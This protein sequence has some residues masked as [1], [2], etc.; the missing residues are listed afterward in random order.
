MGKKIIINESKLRAIVRNILIEQVVDLETAIKEMGFVK[1]TPGNYKHNKDSKLTI[2]IVG[3]NVIV[4]K[5]NKELGKV[6]KNDIE[7]LE[8]IVKSSF[9]LVSEQV[10]KG[11]GNDP[12][13]YKKEGNVYY[14][15]KKGSS[16]WVKTSGEASKAIASKIFKQTTT[17]VQ[18]KSSTPLLTPRF[19]FD[20]P[21]Q[22]SD[23]LG[24]GG[25]FERNLYGGRNKE[26]YFKMMEFV[27]KFPPAKKSSLPLHIRALMDYLA[28]RETPFTAS[29][30]TRDEQQFIKK[31]AISNAKKGLTYPLWK[32]I[33]AGNLPTSMTVTG[34]QKEKEKLTNKGGEGSLIKPELA[35]QFMYTLGEITPPNIKVSPNK[36]NVTVFDRY[37]FNTKG[38][39][40]ED[41]LN[42]FV[43]QVGSWWKGDSTFYS[44][45]RNAVAFKEA[46]GYKG[47]PVNITV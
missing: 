36:E 21:V 38:K 13:E 20:R 2:S 7:D 44:V 47:F 4:K 30:L 45:V 1:T 32:D 12:Y 9:P 15:R 6:T 46:N 27:K 17:K 43:K 34:S 29:D 37:D 14:A 24:K 3:D 26:D 25:E 19:K 35:G 5:G 23:Y 33:G 18:S 39:T 22:Q 31:V 8:G 10:V 28:G 16:S 42:N 40:K 41:L 11:S